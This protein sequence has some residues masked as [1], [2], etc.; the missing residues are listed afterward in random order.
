MGDSKG[1]TLGVALLRSRRIRGHRVG[2][3]GTDGC[4]LLGATKNG[5][6]CEIEMC[7]ELR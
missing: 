6:G 3:G 5:G 2:S 7:L 1:R 4:C